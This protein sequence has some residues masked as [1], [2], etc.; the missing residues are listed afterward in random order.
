MCDADPSAK[1]SR[2]VSDRRVLLRIVPHQAVEF[3]VDQVR[4]VEG[5][6]C[7][8]L[9]PSSFVAPWDV[10]HQACDMLY[11]EAPKAI[12]DSLFRLEV[13]PLLFDVSSGVV[14]HVHLRL[15]SRLTVAVEDLVLAESTLESAVLL[16]EAFMLVGLQV[17]RDTNSVAEIIKRLSGVDVVVLLDGIHFREFFVGYDKE[18]RLLVNG[19]DISMNEI[20]AK[21]SSEISPIDAVDDFVAAG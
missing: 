7:H 13:L 20:H 14:A 15:T 16:F 21:L 12:W 3:K 18:T 9:S 17:V 5:A 4:D 1:L 11:A 2:V 8:Q 6:S 10:L 19:L